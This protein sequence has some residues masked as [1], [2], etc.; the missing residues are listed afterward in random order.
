MSLISHCK[1]D[2]NTSR[3][4]AGQVEGVFQQNKPGSVTD[5]R[6]QHVEQETKESMGYALDTAER[7]ERL[8][9]N[10]LG[11]ANHN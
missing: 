11:R 4:T 6:T 9:Q 10:N 2:S 1:D 5:N 3:G 7:G 8:I